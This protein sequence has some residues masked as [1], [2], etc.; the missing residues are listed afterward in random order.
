MKKNKAQKDILYISI[1]S[2]LVIAVWVS[3]N[4]YHAYVTSTIAPDLQ[5]QIEPI[6]PRFNTDIIQKLKIRKSVIPVFEVSI[7]TPEAK[8]SQPLFPESVTSP[9][10]ISTSSALLSPSSPIDKPIQ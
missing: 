2:F 4:I 6:A 10:P 1:S 9:T 8:I 7:A 5:L 3:S